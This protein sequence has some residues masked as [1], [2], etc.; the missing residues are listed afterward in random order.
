MQTQDKNVNVKMTSILPFHFTAWYA[1]PAS[2]P[3]LHDIHSGRVFCDYGGGCECEEMSDK[4]REKMLLSESCI[5]FFF[6]FFISN[7]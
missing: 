6:S 3:S 1:Y 2:A 4:R 5:S 7:L